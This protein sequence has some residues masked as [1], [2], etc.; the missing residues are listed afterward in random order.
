MKRSQLLRFFLFSFILSIVSF[1]IILE[2]Y[3]Q[4]GQCTVSNSY[5]RKNIQLARRIIKILNELSIA[6]WPDSQT[7]LNVVRNET[8][9]VWDHDVDLSIEW[10]PPSER[11]PLRTSNLDTFMD[12]MR[13]YDLQVDYL[14]ER[15]LIQFRSMDEPSRDRTHVDIWVWYRKEIVDFNEDNDHNN[16]IQTITI[17]E[18]LDYSINYQR[19]IISDIYPLKYTKWLNDN[20]TIAFNSHTIA[21][22]EYGS[23]YMTPV[24]YRKNCFHNM[25]FGRWMV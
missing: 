16:R 7:L 19:R 22:K 1:G 24:V 21:R 25:Y 12:T 8:Y 4:L 20:V 11:S 9:N 5:I 2:L 15:Q 3:Y 18:N 17:L 10:P 23:S 13:K 14:P 6:Y